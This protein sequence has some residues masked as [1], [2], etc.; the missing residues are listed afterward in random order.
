MK[1]KSGRYFC[2]RF[3][4]SKENGQQEIAVDIDCG[5]NN[6]TFDVWFLSFYAAPMIVQSFY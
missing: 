4:H 2:C 6:D 5:N 1:I 3:E